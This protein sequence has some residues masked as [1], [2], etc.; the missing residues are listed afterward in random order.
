MFEHVECISFSPDV[1]HRHRITVMHRSNY[2]E[3]LWIYTGVAI[4]EPWF[5]PLS[6]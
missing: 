1:V 3:K 5:P 6:T 4:D 2:G